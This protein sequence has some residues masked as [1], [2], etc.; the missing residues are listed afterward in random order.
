MYWQNCIQTVTKRF[1]NYN[2]LTVRL[3]S[4][5]YNLLSLI[6]LFHT[7]IIHCSH[8]RSFTETV[9][10]WFDYYKALK[11]AC[12]YHL[13]SP[14]FSTGKTLTGGSSHPPELQ[15]SWLPKLINPCHTANTTKSFHTWLNWKCIFDNFLEFQTWLHKEILLLLGTSYY[16]FH[17]S[18]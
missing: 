13:A 12:F 18:S 4:E 9:Q 3:C 11:H 2:M 6:I 17:W 16:I 14:V 8:P 1:Q 10:I 15:N 5:F 7:F